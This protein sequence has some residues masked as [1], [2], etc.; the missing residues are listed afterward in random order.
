MDK[1]LKVG[2][3]REVNFF[4]WLANMALVKKTTKKWCICINYTNLN[5]VCLKDSYPLSQI[6]QLI[7][8]A[9]SQL[10]SFIDVFSEYNQNMTSEDEEKTAFTIDQEFFFCYRVM[11]LA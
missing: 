3:V 8:T 1:L 7:H 10:L 9:S 11:P 2:F 6:N 5:K 4:E